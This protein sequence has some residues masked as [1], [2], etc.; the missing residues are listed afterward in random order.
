M[1]ILIVGLVIMLG[2]HSIKIVAPGWRA[3]MMARFG[4][5]PYKGVY[6]LAAALGLVLIVWGFV[7]AWDDP[8]FLYT[9]PIWA[10]RFPHTPPRLSRIS[11]FRRSA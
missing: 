4:E 6:S 11:I 2:V 1:A 5:G 8:V 7:R 9:P 3:A 10:R